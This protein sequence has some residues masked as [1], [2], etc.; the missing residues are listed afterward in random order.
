VKGLPGTI[1]PDWAE[2]APCDCQAEV[3]G[4]TPLTAGGPVRIMVCP[5]N[6]PRVAWAWYTRQG[7]PKLFMVTSVEG[8]EGVGL[9]SVLDYWKWLPGH[10][11]PRSAFAKPAICEAGASHRQPDLHRCA[12]CHFGESPN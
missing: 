3:A 2:R 9:F 7:D 4:G 10:A 8:D 11:V 12:T 6:E 5:L 1:R